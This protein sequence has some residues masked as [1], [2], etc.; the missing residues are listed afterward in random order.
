MSKGDSEDQKSSQE[1]KGKTSFFPFLWHT[2][3]KPIGW[4]H[5]H[6]EWVFPL[7]FEANMSIIQTYPELYSI[8]PLGISYS[9]QVDVMVNYYSKACNFYLFK[10][11]PGNIELTLF[12][13]H[14]MLNS[15]S[16]SKT[17]AECTFYCQC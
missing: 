4:C 2:G 15:V 11:I 17:T 9:L 14:H 13:R 1:A 7:Q 5:S 10:N 6:P 12:C 8:N 3:C 16:P